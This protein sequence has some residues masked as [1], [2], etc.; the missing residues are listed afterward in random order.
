MSALQPIQ[1]LKNNAAARYMLIAG[2]FFALMQVCVK[3]VAHLPTIEI[4]FFR[5]IVTLVISGYFILKA[6]LS[7]W[8]NNKKLLI[9][10][11]LFGLASLWMFFT[12]LQKLPMAT[13][14]SIQ[15]TSPLFT[16]LIAIW[17]L[18]EK[19]QQV[20]W[21]GFA[22]SILGVLAIKGFNQDI[23][24]EYV[25][26][27]LLSAVGSGFAYNFIRKLKGVDH[28]MVIVFY[29]P[30]VAAPI[31]G[32]ALIGQWV[33]PIGIEWMWLLFMGICTQIAQLYMTYAWQSDSASKVASLQY[34]GIAF[35]LFFDVVLYAVVP[36][37]SMV[38]GIALILGGVILNHRKTA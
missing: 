9:L 7:P 11:G 21:I 2:F 17:F 22:L 4:V 31:A 12:T 20:Q 10:R 6:R 15:Y 33:Q 25:L 36:S 38:I 16:A 14:S 23:A 13:A 35:A 26:I 19:M 8:G 34:V 32:I 3:Q 24:W 1:F 30:L 18:G 27:G 37:V 5:A 28:P 29:F